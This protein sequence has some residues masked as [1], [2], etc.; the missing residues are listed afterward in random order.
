MN[1]NKDMYVLMPVLQ[2]KDIFYY[3]LRL[4]LYLDI[5]LSSTLHNNPIVY[6]K[7]NLFSLFLCCQNLLWFKHVCRNNKKLKKDVYYEN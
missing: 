4:L 7:K 3:K 1:W 5:K 6:E 2:Y